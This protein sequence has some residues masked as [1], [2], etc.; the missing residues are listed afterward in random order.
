MEHCH[1]IFDYRFFFNNQSH[2][3]GKY[4]NSY[5]FVF[6]EKDTSKASKFG[7]CIVND[8]AVTKY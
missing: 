2:L 3:T 6:A 7:F 1:E 5:G 8:T 4:H